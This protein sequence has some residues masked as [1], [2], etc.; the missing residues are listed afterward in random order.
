VCGQD[1]VQYEFEKG[2][3]RD[4]KKMKPLCKKHKMEGTFLPSRGTYKKC[5]KCGYYESTHGGSYF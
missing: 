1:F 5:H 4:F 3:W 2:K